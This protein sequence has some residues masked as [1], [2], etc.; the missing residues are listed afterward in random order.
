MS[1][2]LMPWS[3]NQAVLEL[4]LIKTQAHF[5]QYLKERMTYW[6]FKATFEFLR[7]FALECMYVS[8]FKTVLIILKYHTQTCYLGFGCPSP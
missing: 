7:Q 1:Q 5:D 6:N 8:L 3:N 2:K 4:L